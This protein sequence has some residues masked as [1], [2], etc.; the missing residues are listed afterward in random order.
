MSTVQTSTFTVL[1]ARYRK[2]SD[3]KITAFLQVQSHPNAPVGYVRWTTTQPPLAGTRIEATG[4]IVQS[5][6]GPVMHVAGDNNVRLLSGQQG[7]ILHKT[8]KTLLDRF[9]IA[10]T[11][12]K[13]EAALQDPK[14]HLA[15]MNHA[16]L[17]DALHHADVPDA[18]NVV[19]AREETF[20]DAL[21]RNFF[22]GLEPIRLPYDTDTKRDLPFAKGT[23][24]V[25]IMDGCM[26]QFIECTQGQKPHRA[27]P[28]GRPFYLTRHVTYDGI[29]NFYRALSIAMDTPDVF[30]RWVR[31][32][33]RPSALTQCYIEDKQAHGTQIFTG[34]D[35]KQLDRL[36]LQGASKIAARLGNMVQLPPAADGTTRMMPLG[37]YQSSARL[38][39]LEKLETHAS[40]LNV[41]IQDAHLD[42][43]QKKAL[44][45][46]VEGKP[47]T[48]ISGPPGSGKSTLIASMIEHA[49]RSGTPVV[50]VTPTGKSASR[51]NASFETVFPDSKTR[52]VA[53]TIHAMFYNNAAHRKA[54]RSMPLLNTSALRDALD[55]QATDSFPVAVERAM[56]FSSYK[57]NKTDTPK[58]ETLLMG[59]IVPAEILRG[60]IVIVDESTQVTG[61][62]MALLCEMRPKK[63][64]LTG[65]LSQLKPVG[66]GK[67]FHD[68]IHLAKT[69]YM[70]E[71]MNAVELQIDHRATKELA[72][73][74]RKLREGAL[75]LDY[76]ETFNGD[77]DATIA[78]WDDREAVVLECKK[79]GHAIDVVE[80]L[81]ARTV[82]Q[83]NA[84]FDV[85]HGQA[86][87][88][89][90]AIRLSE[91]LAPNLFAQTIASPSLMA[92]AYTN[93]EVGHL[94]ERM[95]SVLRP[96]MHVGSDFASVSALAPV[97][98][99]GIRLGD[100]ILQTEN[101]KQR[102]VYTTPAGPRLS[103]GSMNGETFVLLGAHTWLPLPTSN[104]P[105]ALR[106]WW[107]AT[108]LDKDAA[109]MLLHR[110]DDPVAH[111]ELTTKLQALHTPE[112][113]R[114]LA[115]GLSEMLV[116]DQAKLRPGEEIALEEHDIKRF[117]FPPVPPKK[118]EKDNAEFDAF[119]GVVKHTWRL[120]TTGL[121]AKPGKA[122]IIEFPAYK[123]AYQKLMN[124]V[125]SF[126]LGF[127]ST[128]HKAQGS[129]AKV[130]VSVV[131]PPARDDDAAT[132][133]A[134]VYT[135]TTRAE[136]ASYVLI[137]GTTADHLNAQWAQA[138]E[139]ENARPSPITMIA[140]GDIP[141]IGES[142]QLMTPIP[143]QH[144]DEPLYARTLRA[145][146][147]MASHGFPATLS[148]ANAPT[149]VR[150]SMASMTQNE[151]LATLGLPTLPGMLDAPTHLLPDRKKHFAWDPAAVLPGQHIPIEN[152]DLSETLATMDF[153]FD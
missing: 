20:A 57:D 5:G 101:S 42:P 48:L 135:A 51:L 115:L 100:A 108:G 22:H 73:F 44:H 106:A 75:P 121:N 60:A 96:L 27:I 131:A 37:A 32:K 72:D 133:E 147:T 6:Q 15:S 83:Q 140:S 17:V 98:A 38:A 29:D 2:A 116:V 50:V 143:P 88:S 25:D 52:P 141:N 110:H 153:G 129:Q 89:R 130:A 64:V 91:R 54:H 144:K 35:M 86:P 13:L 125:E 112:A 43:F 36:G 134:S 67:P 87:T 70:P 1:A 8:V 149:Y 3:G 24:P 114:I 16:M 10:Y 45:A 23:W 128:I 111:W 34:D 117:V 94:N 49:S 68:L 103:S 104:A 33:S 76:V 19:T 26:P 9:S 4:T 151:K 99:S 109:D 53:T 142:M 77:A 148:L 56:R 118:Q 122:G 152:I 127:A 62:L 11:P 138:R 90:T 30:P 81:T 46:F 59:E 113:Q 137:H 102:M 7:Q 69:G 139:L 120:D 12:A 18:E 79:M 119:M 41:E 65:D 107:T 92:M 136:A 14:M 78:E 150:E 85:V 84:L 40:P 126:T 95:G 61:D 47:L 123:T 145:R 93:A 146:A 105:P 74:T 39:H 80:H 63:M 28:N 132:H 124:G 66:P 31:D 21:T 71:R 82:A 55:S 58:P 97:A